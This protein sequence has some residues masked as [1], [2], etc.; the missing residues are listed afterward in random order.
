MSATETSYSLAFDLIR[1]YAEREGWVPIGWREW[2]VG[3]WHIRVNGTAEPRG[4]IP[5]YHA[6][7]ENETYVALLLIHPLG[8]TVGGWTGAE[9]EFIAA[10]ER[11]LA[12][13]P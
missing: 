11:E 13:Q 6:L 10:M 12:V 4:A 8:G 1:R 7:I 2:H 5:P 3:P 9:E